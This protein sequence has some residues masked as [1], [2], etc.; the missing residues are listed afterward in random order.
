M[1]IG[2]VSKI[3]LALAV[4]APSAL[5]SQSM[6][7]T[8]VRGDIQAQF[9]AAADKLVQLAEAIPAD[10]YGWRP[11]EGVRSVSEVFMHVAGGNYLFTRFVGSQMAAPFG[12]DAETAVT[13][14]ARVIDQLK[15]SV[16]QTN[17]VFDGLS[18]ADLDKPTS[19]FG[20]ETTYR[21]VLMVLVSH[22]HEHLGQMI[23]Y[24]RSNGVTPPWS[25]PE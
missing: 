10:K 2:T 20:N 16:E 25:R 11:A 13:D 23:A 7:P 12:S 8:G 15:R 24:A 22:E 17:N 3:A 1:R 21:G 4:A 5:S 14:K 19:L 18:E 9:N 6:M